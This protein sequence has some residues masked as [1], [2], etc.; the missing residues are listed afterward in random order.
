MYSLGETHVEVAL[1]ISH[2]KVEPLSEEVKI[3][4]I[5]V[6]ATLAVEVEVIVV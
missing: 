3:K 5:V 6:V 4:D 1:S 2:S